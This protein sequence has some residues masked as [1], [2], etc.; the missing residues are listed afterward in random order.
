MC[1]TQVPA[2]FVLLCNASFRQPADKTPRR[3]LA[4]SGSAR[5]ARRREDV[6]ARKPRRPPQGDQAP[7]REPAGKR[8]E[9]ALYQHCVSPR[10]SLRGCPR[11]WPRCTGQPGPG[12]VLAARFRRSKRT[13]QMTSGRSGRTRNDPA[14]SQP[15]SPARRPVRRPRQGRTFC[16]MNEP[17]VAGSEPTAARGREARGAQIR[18]C[19]TPTSTSTQSIRARAAGTATSRILPPER[20]ARVSAWSVPETSLI[21]HGQTNLKT[22]LFPQKRAC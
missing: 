6:T 22:V 14:T 15:G 2:I 13:D 11:R 10:A 12:A 20:C 16:L 18:Q 19:S 5:A 3:A 7:R 21:P 9:P 1:S 4:L 8:Q 17:G